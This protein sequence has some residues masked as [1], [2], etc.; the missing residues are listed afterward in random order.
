M[1]TITGILYEPVVFTVPLDGGAFEVPGA[2]SAV[3]NDESIVRQARCQFYVEVEEVNA[4]CEV[5]R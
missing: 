1:A 5:G 3:V 2:T 4:R